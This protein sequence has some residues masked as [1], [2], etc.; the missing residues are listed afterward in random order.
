VL[1]A[2]QRVLAVAARVTERRAAN[3]AWQLLY[4]RERLRWMEERMG[5]NVALL[6]SYLALAGEEETVLPSG[7]ILIREE[8]GEAPVEVRRTA[9]DDG[10]EELRP[11]TCVPARRG[12]QSDRTRS[13]KRHRWMADAGTGLRLP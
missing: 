10:F 1:V 11:A 2:A 3:A 13:P 8:G 9:A 7:Y 12:S 4:H 5:E 6:E